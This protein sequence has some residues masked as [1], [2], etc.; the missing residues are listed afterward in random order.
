MDVFTLINSKDIREYLRNQ[1]YKFNSLETAWLIYQ[2]HRLSYEEKKVLWRELIDTTPDC[3]Q[4]PKGYDLG[5]TS[6][7][8]SLKLYMDT[9]DMILYLRR[10][11]EL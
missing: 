7:H 4:P 9:V 3:G 11:E 2:C 10:G 6:L 5:W 8:E 1:D